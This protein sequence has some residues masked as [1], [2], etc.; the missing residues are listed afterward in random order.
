MQAD[1]VAVKM[2]EIMAAK[3]ETVTIENGAISLGVSV[4]SNGDFRAV[5]KDWA[6]VALKDENVKV[7]NGR[8]VITLPIEG[9]SGFM[10]LQSG[11]AKVGGD[12]E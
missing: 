7:E 9:V 11:D 12:S 4:C 6:K 8:I 1:E 3:A 5:T 10:I 2:T